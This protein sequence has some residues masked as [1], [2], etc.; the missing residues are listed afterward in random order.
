M[1][2]QRALELADSLLESDYGKH[3]DFFIKMI[4]T[5]Y[6]EGFT[7]LSD[8]VKTMRSEDSKS[9][10]YAVKLHDAMNRL[11]EYLDREYQGK[12][13]VLKTAV[14]IRIVD[15]IFKANRIARQK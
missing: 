1:S 5:E 11:F 7:I 15:D 10:V 14:C 12:D 4:K 2:Y 3:R 13:P 6:P 8:V 9:P